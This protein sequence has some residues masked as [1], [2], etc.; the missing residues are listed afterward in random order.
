MR[1]QVVKKVSITAKIIKERVSFFKS[2]Q[3]YRIAKQMG[4]LVELMG[5]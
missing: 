2:L 1:S 4:K 3:Y 5:E